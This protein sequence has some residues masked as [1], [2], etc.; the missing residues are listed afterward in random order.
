MI[1]E[2]YQMFSDVLSNDWVTQMTEWSDRVHLCR[3]YAM[4]DHRQEITSEMAQLLRI[5]QTD[6]LD[7]FNANY[8]QKV[9][10]AMADRLIVSQ[11]AVNDDMAQVW[12]DDLLRVNRWDGLQMDVHEAVV[13]DGDTFVMA[14]WDE[15]RGRVRLSHE[16]AYDGDWG[17]IPIYSRS[18]RRNLHAA[19]KIVGVGDEEYMVYVYHADRVETYKADSEHG[20]LHPYVMDEAESHV[21]SWIVGQFPVVHYSNRPNTMT[22]LGSSELIA[23]IPLNDVI[24][25]TIM[26]MV[27]ASELSAFQI[28][29]L[30]GAEAPSKVTPGMIMNIGKEGI[31]KDEVQMP[32][33]GT[34]AQNSPVPFLEVI[35]SMIDKIS[36]VTSTPIHLGSAAQSGEAL[37]QR[38][39]ALLAKVRRAQV[40]LGNRHEDMITLAANV[41][42]VYGTMAVPVV[43][44][45]NTQWVDAQ[46][47]ND[48][49]VV[50]NAVTTF[51]VTND[52]ELYLQNISPVYGWTED[53]RSEIL[54]RITQQRRDVLSF[55]A[56]PP[57]NF[58]PV[59]NSEAV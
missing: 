23:G 29:Y 21:Q 26:S 34:V 4:G 51:G 57:L 33:V 27:A 2:I 40:K 48:R 1:H 13:R 11:M 3:E 41:A 50:E 31:P 37:K 39:V 44:T 35:D 53:D 8:M 15:A 54:D 14:V 12:V 5:D 36:D 28:M 32:V 19:V 49:E 20:G 43:D 47:R 38:E 17:M 52:V 56:A 16:L 46:V 7:H 6:V 30:I 59:L 45:V 10:D 42:R 9:I 18:D 24:N 22:G 25:R 58:D 55:A